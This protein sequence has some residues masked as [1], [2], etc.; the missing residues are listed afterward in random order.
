[1]SFI[2]RWRLSYSIMKPLVAAQVTTV[3]PRAAMNTE[4]PMVWRPGCSNTMVGSS[5]ISE[6]TFLP[7]RRH[8]D[9]SWV[10]SSFQNV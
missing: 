7:S 4:A 10:W 5:P 3:P 9:S 6:R 1:L 2:H 8:S